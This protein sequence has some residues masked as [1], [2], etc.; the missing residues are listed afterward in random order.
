MVP[1]IL[2]NV[3]LL[4]IDEVPAG[5]EMR[6]QIFNYRTSQA[7]RQIR[8]AHSRALG[9]IKFIIF[10]LFHGL[11]VSDACIVVILTRKQS[12]VEVSWVRVGDWM[13]IRVPSAEAKIKTAHESDIAI[14]ETEFLVMCPV[15]NDIFVDTIECF[16]SISGDFG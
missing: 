2:L 6:L 14:D 1:V 5:D 3:I 16:E 8:P 13:L 7:N 9:S 10:P 12:F 11:K 4:I 15:E